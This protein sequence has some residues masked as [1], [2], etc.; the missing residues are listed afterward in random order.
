MGHS[1]DTC[2][3]NQLQNFAWNSSY[4][5]DDIKY[6]R[7]LDDT[8]VTP[9]PLCKNWPNETISSRMMAKARELRC[10][11]NIRSL[12]SL[13]CALETE[14]KSAST[15]QKVQEAVAWLVLMSGILLALC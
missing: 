6:Y 13:G 4:H 7:C 3:A 10:A 15:Q 2:E 14:K 1:P 11:G 8:V 12:A 9:E 5:A